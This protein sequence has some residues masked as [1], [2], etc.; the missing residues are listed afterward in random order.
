MKQ[1][2]SRHCT[3]GNKVILEVH[4]INESY[5]YPSLLPLQSLLAAAQGEETPAEHNRILS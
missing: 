3:S 5:G 1:W 4:E 2:F